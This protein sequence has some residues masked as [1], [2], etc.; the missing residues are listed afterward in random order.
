MEDVFTNQREKKKKEVV[1]QVSRNRVQYVV[2]TDEKEKGGVPYTHTLSL[3]SI[4]MAG[5]NGLVRKRFGCSR[6]PCYSRSK[7][8]FRSF[9][10][11]EEQQE[12]EEEEEEEG[13]EE[14]DEEE[15]APAGATP[16]AISESAVVAPSAV[17]LTLL[18]QLEEKP[19]GRFHL[20]VTLLV[21]VV[22]VDGVGGVED[23]VLASP[24][25]KESPVILPVRPGDSRADR[26]CS[27][28]SSSSQF[29][30]QFHYRV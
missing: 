28:S 7:L 29:V 9:Q 6:S 1:Y 19:R 17:A 16:C 22:V 15:R 21:I 18:Q 5:H 30:L 4:R 11:R 12:E 13:K 14:Q 2:S 26:S 27:S 25:H 8:A 20:P 3:N 10:S 24:I 23:D